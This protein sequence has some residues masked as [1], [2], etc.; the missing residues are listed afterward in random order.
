MPSPNPTEKD[1]YIQIADALEEAE[2]ADIWYDAREF[3]DQDAVEK[4][5]TAQQAMKEA[6]EI[7]R[8]LAGEGPALKPAS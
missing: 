3:D 7:L 2:A 8:S 4:I 1:R 5:E 6:A